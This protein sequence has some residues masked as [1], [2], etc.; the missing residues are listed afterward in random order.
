MPW[1][2]GLDIIHHYQQTP[3][4]SLHYI[5]TTEAL[6][7]ECEASFYPDHI[8]ISRQCCVAMLNVSGALNSHCVPPGDLRCVY[9]NNGDSI[10]F[11]IASV[12]TLDTA[13]Y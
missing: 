2:P 5:Q 13:I 7:P 6:Y 8:I 4:E 10:Y 1:H 3:A 12:T 9:L 11:T